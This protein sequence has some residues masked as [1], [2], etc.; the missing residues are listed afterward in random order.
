MDRIQS[1]TIE[2]EEHSRADHDY[3][4]TVA[5]V[6]SVA[7]RSNDIFEGAELHEKRQFIN[8][9]VQNPQMKDRELVFELKSPMNTIL[10][11]AHYTSQ[12][13]KTTSLSTDRST[14]LRVID[15]VRTAIEAHDGYISIPKLTVAN[16]VY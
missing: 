14:W 3:K 4:T 12:E 7:R 9:L 1:L 5:T 13:R 16:L 2:M 8:F 15:E 6:L 10:E 11:L